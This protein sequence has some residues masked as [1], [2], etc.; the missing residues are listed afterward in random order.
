MLDFY[1]KIGYKQVDEMPVEKIIKSKLTR[2]GLT[3]IML[4]KHHAGRK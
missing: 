3:F 4:Q 2:S 1:A